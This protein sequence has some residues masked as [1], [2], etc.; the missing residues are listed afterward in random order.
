M[1]TLQNLSDKQLYLFTYLVGIIVIALFDFGAISDSVLLF[2]LISPIVAPL[3]GFIAFM[4]VTLPLGALL[5]IYD[6]VRFVYKK[7]KLT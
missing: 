4:A 1:N 3:T 2:A 7:V 6:L 5:Y